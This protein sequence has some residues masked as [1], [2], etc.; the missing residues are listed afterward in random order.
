MS[1]ERDARNAAYAFVDKLHSI[2]PQRAMS[3]AGRRELV[4]LAQAFINASKAADS[5]ARALEIV[6]VIGEDEFQR[7]SAEERANA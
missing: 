2:S 4:A 6:R 5:L 1:A 7:L 3:A